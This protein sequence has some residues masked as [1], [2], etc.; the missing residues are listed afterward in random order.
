MG[1]AAPP[2]GAG[3]LEAGCDHRIRSHLRGELG[4]LLGAG[5]AQSSR[6]CAR[7]DL[8]QRVG[9]WGP[10][11]GGFA[12]RG[13]GPH[14]TEPGSMWGTDVL[15]PQLLF[16]NSKTVRRTVSPFLLLPWVVGLSILRVGP[17]V[18]LPSQTSVQG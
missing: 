13:E 3:W 8:D 10:R 14:T 2:S 7:L 15:E 18:D 4:L 17:D 12:L 11:G 16:G 1:E 6:S 5:D 9:S